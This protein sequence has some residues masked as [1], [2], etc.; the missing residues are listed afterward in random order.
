MSLNPTLLVF[1][2]VFTY[3][4]SFFFLL[5]F[6]YY[7]RPKSYITKKKE[8]KTDKKSCTYPN[9]NSSRVNRNKI[10]IDRIKIKENP[11]TDKFIL[12]LIQ[13]LSQ[14]NNRM[15]HLHPPPS[16]LRPNW[17]THLCTEYLYTMKSKK[18][19]EYNIKTLQKISIFSI[20]LTKNF[21]KPPPHTQLNSFSNIN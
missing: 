2:F 13:I 11:I 14:A 3:I 5:S 18:S 17:L 10:G 12:N 20:I 21:L 16:T 8:T 9:Q 6:I 7:F 19:A 4:F 1:L 15:C